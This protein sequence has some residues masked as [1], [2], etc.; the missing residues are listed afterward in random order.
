MLKTYSV[1]MLAVFLSACG[2]QD[3]SAVE[4]PAEASHASSAIR[5]PETVFEFTTDKLNS[6][7]LTVGLPVNKPTV[8]KSVDGFKRRRWQVIGMDESNMLEAVG[9]NQQ[10]VRVLSGHCMEYSTDGNSAGWA[11]DG[12]CVEIFNGI[13]GKLVASNEDVFGLLME[14]AGLYPYIPQAPMAVIDRGSISIDVDNQ[15]YFSIRNRAAH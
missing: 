3:T 5:P 10:D 8:D 11:P 13:V 12:R 7:E 1:L 14:R 6:D 9:D 15:G 2:G 4:Q